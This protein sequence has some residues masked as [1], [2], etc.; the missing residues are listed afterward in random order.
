MGAPTLNSSTVNG[1]LKLLLWQEWVIVC[2]PGEGPEMIPLEVSFGCQ[3]V[4]TDL[5]W[6]GEVR[7]FSQNN[8]LFMMV[9]IYWFDCLKDSLSFIG[10]LF[11]G[12]F[13]M[14]TSAGL[15]F[16]IFL[17]CSV[18]LLW[19]IQLPFFISWNVLISI[20]EKVMLDSLLP[21]KFVWQDFRFCLEKN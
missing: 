17:S 18:V 7:L 5:L 21:Q 15:H 1:L 11:N 3:R 4:D 19:A 16:H 10:P 20:L 14:Q 2:Q 12:P 9:L 8:A 13:I 6:T